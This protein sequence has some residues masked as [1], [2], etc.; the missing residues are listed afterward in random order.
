MGRGVGPLPEESGTGAEQE[1]TTWLFREPQQ[2]CKAQGRC[3]TPVILALGRWRQED[4]EFSATLA[5]PCLEQQANE[6]H[7]IADVRAGQEWS[8]IGLSVWLGW[9]AGQSAVTGVYGNATG[10][11]SRVVTKTSAGEERS[12]LSDFNPGKV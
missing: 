4:G 9:S 6:E 10:P 8:Q 2:H 5:R 11:L 1:N 7:T 3:C 12:R